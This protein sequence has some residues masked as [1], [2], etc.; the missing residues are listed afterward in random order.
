[1]STLLARR[2]AAIGCRRRKL[3]A[4]RQA[5]LAHLRNG[6]TYSRLAAGFRVA[7]AT[8]SCYLRKAADLLAA[9]AAHGH[10]SSPGQGVRGARRHPDPHQP[11][12]RTRQ[13]RP[14][15]LLR[16][17]QAARRQ[18]ATARRPGRLIWALPTWP[19]ATHDLTAACT[20]S[21]IAALTR[22]AV[23][24]FAGKGYPGHRPPC[25]GR[26]LPAAWTQANHA[27]TAIRA[28]GERAVATLK[29]WRILTKLRCCPQRTTALAAAILTFEPNQQ[30]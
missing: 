29:T 7:V 11:G 19:G 1:M 3:S 13:D 6:D 21:L 24:T 15:L 9:T 30:G 17:A 25:K 4:S 12:R 16:Q 22:A 20:H 27:H 5:L 10:P 23:A 18:R 14:A 26:H 2:R 28:P 8:V